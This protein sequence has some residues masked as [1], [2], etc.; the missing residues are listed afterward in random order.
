MKNSLLI[1]AFRSKEKYMKQRFKM[2]CAANYV[3]TGKRRYLIERFLTKW[4]KKELKKKNRIELKSIKPLF[5]VNYTVDM[6]FSTHRNHTLVAFF[7]RVV[8]K[9]DC[10]ANKEL[11]IGVKSFV[12]KLASWKSLTIS[13]YS[14]RKMVCLCMKHN[15]GN[16]TA[17]RC[18][19]STYKLTFQNDYAGQ[20][21]WC[22]NIFFLGCMW[23]T[24]SDEYILLQRFGVLQF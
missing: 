20:L 1:R 10:C 18:L 19:Y 5:H 21:K 8:N 22:H 4:E 12:D 16:S 23:I 7:F 2:K 6:M 17:G 15:A 24:G 11:K 9:C 14:T 13:I 3:R